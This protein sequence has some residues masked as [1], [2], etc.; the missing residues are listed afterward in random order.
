MSYGEVVFGKAL[1][2][3]R[4][5]VLEK[6]RHRSP[7]RKGNYFYISSWATGYSDIQ[8]NIILDVFV[9]VLLDES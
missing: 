4:T 6:G 3:R 1:L 9:K 2:V 7:R 5:L 8:S